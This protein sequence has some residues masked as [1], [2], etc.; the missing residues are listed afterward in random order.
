MKKAVLA[1][2]ATILFSLSVYAQ[3]KSFLYE[4]SGKNLPQPSY[5]FGT[6]HLVCPADLQLSDA[7][8]KALGD[9]KQLYLEIDFDD[10][11]LQT[12]MIAGM[13]LGG[14]KNL[15]DFLKPEDYTVLDMYLQ[16]NLGTGLAQVGN[17][18][19]IAL[20]SVL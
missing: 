18:K 6:F 15:K 3:D 19:P 2:L 1:L 13:I 16:Q 17:L 20:L 4:V 12:K 11:S 9:S 5:L 7:S 10:P 8:R 14:G